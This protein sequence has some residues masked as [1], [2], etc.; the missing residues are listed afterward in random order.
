MLDLFSGR[1]GWSAAFRD[2]GHIVLTLDNDAAGRF[3]ADYRCDILEVQSLNALERKGKFDVVLASPP[4]ECFSVASISRH[5][6]GGLRAYQPGS[7]E[8][9]NA[10]HV[11]THTFGLVESYRPRYAV[12]ENPRGVM[13]KVAPRQPTTTTWYCQWGDSRAKPTDLWLWGFYG[14]LPRCQNGATDHAPGPRG[15]KT[16]GSTQGIQLSRNRALVP[17]RLSLALCQAAEADGCIRVV[18]AQD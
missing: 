7:R 8:A 9:R 12:I 4:C 15:S 5:W 11:M 14:D 10:L 3:E 17:Y 2:R 16:P 6:T 18:H 13:R 1:G